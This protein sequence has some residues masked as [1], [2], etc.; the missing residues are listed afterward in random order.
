MTRNCGTCRYFYRMDESRQGECRR[1]SP[2]II[3]GMLTEYGDQDS[4]GYWPLVMDDYCCG[5]VHTKEG[6]T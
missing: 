3:T 4:W 6:K 5:E 1:Y 2:R